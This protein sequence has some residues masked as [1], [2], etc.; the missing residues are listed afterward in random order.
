MKGKFTLVILLSL[1]G[2]L[3]VYSQIRNKPLTDLSTFEMNRQKAIGVQPLSEGI[4]LLPFTEHKV[5]SVLSFTWDTLTHVWT[6]WKKE[7]RSYNIEGLPTEI[8][9]FITDSTTG[10]R[11]Y[12][13][14]TT[15]YSIAG[16]MIK[17]TWYG[18][19]RVTSSWVISAYQEVNETG[20][21][22]FNYYYQYDLMN[23]TILSGGKTKYIYDSTGT[24]TELINQIWETGSSSW[25]NSSHTINILENYLLVEHIDQAWNTD[26]A[27]WLN[28]YHEL[29]T[30]DVN[31]RQVDYTMAFWY[32][33]QWQNMIKKTNVYDSLQSLKFIDQYYWNTGTLSWDTNGRYSFQYTSTGGLDH[34]YYL[35]YDTVVNGFDSNYRYS[36]AYYHN[37]SLDS[38]I[39]EFNNLTA[40]EWMLNYYMHNDS[41]YHLLEYYNKFYDPTSF[42]FTG[43]NRSTSVYDTA[44]KQIQS[45]SQFWDSGLN[46]WLNQSRALLVYDTLGFILKETDQVWKTLA[47]TWENS[48][49]YS[50]Y[51]TRPA[52]IEEQIQPGQLCFYSNPLKRGE[53]IRCTSLTDNRDY[54]FA[55]YSVSGSL[56]Y[57][58]DFKGRN[59]WVY[60]GYAAPGVYLMTLT[61]QGKLI[62]SGKIIVL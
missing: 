58:H 30:Y 22:V 12:Q 23:N 36:W 44:G 54:R 57:T 20:R 60:D 21:P 24:N 7:S 26:S 3:Q 47:A 42:Q 34:E 4:S 17:D 2:T 32:F 15:E 29:Y 61:S 9:Y 41:L 19:N 14:H 49:L 59:S 51:Y 11:N 48:I 52:G 18:W 10:W 56:V 8:L 45:V 27:K 53:S 37:G 25:I 43:G 62:S 40:G 35:L 1:M 55:L 5:D 6:P 33:S 39:G 13:K 38:Q 50:Y 31:R 28:N 46:D 16:L